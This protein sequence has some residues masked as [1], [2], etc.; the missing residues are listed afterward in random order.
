[1]IKKRDQIKMK[2]QLS[3]NAAKTMPESQLNQITVG[4]EDMISSNDRTTMMTHLQNDTSRNVNNRTVD[5]SFT[6]VLPK[7]M[8]NIHF[9]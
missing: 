7:I 6:P 9:N 8:N 1:M 4:A 2:D 5:I 3:L